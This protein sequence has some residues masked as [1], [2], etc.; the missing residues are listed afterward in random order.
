MGVGTALE[1]PLSQR[2]Q[3]AFLGTVPEDLVLSPCFNLG[4]IRA[5]TMEA[6]PRPGAHGPTEFSPAW[7]GGRR[8]PLMVSVPRI[9]EGQ[10]EPVLTVRHPP[11]VLV[12]DEEN[13]QW[14]PPTHLFPENWNP[15]PHFRAWS[16]E[17]GNKR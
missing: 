6:Q 13:L 15:H 7:G 10:T 9:Q 11:G 16:R 2:S 5:P 4:R 8:C 17:E 3:R 12:P 1:L 14:T